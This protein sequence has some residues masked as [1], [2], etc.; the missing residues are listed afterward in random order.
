MAAIDSRSETA[1]RGPRIAGIDALRGAAILAMIAYHL[2][3]D[4]SAHGIIAV[5]V[6]NTLGWKIFARTIAGSFLAIV[7]VSLVL[8]GRN[9]FRPAAFL[10]R[11]A[12][13]AAAAALVSL[14]T[15][16][17]LPDAFVFFG[18]LHAIAVSSVL[19]LPFLRAPAWFTAV[20]G[21]LVI[22]GPWFLADP[23]FNAPGWLWL[24]LATV[25]P[26]T[27]DYVPLFPWFGVVLLGVAAGRLLVQTGGGRFARWRAA[28][29]AARSLIF[30]GRWSLLIYLLHQPF[31]L[32]ILFVVAP[33][34]G[35]G[36]EALARIY[37][38][39]YAVGCVAEGYDQ[40]TCEAY[41]ACILTKVRAEPD[42][43]A[44]AAAERLSESDRQRWEDDVIAC[45]IAVLP[46]PALDGST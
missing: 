10:R 8:A 34:I 33:L 37:G 9:G 42:L 41:A 15:Y 27:V 35:P 2:S 17:F 6:V 19:A 40:A 21:A 25:P 30:A 5:D 28:G 11:L 23:V 1:A 7:G 31:L 22:A 14:G 16:W 43:L 45:R 12:I 46:P 39:Q 29:P 44:D 32:G 18:I 36:P 26:R 24:G 3:W 13:I 38:Q 20:F 4:L